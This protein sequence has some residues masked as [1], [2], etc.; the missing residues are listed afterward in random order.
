MFGITLGACA[1]RESASRPRS[2]YPSHRNAA[3]LWMSSNEQKV[4]EDAAVDVLKTT[5]DI[6]S[7]W[8]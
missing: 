5:G 4:V 3:E 6:K 2:R 8:L 1:S 7:R